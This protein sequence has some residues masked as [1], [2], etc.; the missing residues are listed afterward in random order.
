LTG[1][2]QYPSPLDHLTKKLSHKGDY[3]GSSGGSARWA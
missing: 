1:P 3:C 2:P